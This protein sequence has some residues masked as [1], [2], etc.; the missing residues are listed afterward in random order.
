MPSGRVLVAG[1]AA[2]IPALLALLARRMVDRFVV[3]NRS[4]LPTL[5]PGDRLLIDRLVFRVGRL[6]RGDLVLFR[7]PRESE[8]LLIKRVIGLP[9]EHVALDGGLRIDGSPMPEPYLLDDG[10]PT[11]PA[12]WLLGQDE[13]LLLGDNRGESR[14]GRHFGPVHSDA[15]V[16]RAWFRYCPPERRGRLL[17]RA[18]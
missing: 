14:D 12:E 7:H 4:M 6:S 1:S 5:R 16:G 10:L 2:L 8:R 3:A 11:P 15:L 18:N 9:A 17:G 13:Y